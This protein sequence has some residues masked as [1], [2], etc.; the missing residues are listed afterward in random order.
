[1]LLVLSTA[2]EAKK[3]EIY[4]C[5][6][7]DGTVVIQDR[8][9]M[10]TDLHSVK[11]SKHQK[12]QVNQRANNQSSSPNNRQSQ[13]PVEISKHSFIT[14]E[15]I[16]SGRSPFFDLG[17]DQFIPAYWNKLKTNSRNHQQLL[18]S[19]AQLKN[20]SGFK[21]GVKLSVYS[22]AM[23]RSQQDPF[24]KA[25]QLY[26]QIRNNDSFQ[27]L[28]S[29]FKAHPNYKV[30]NIKYQ[31]QTQQLLLTEFYIDEKHNDLFVVTIQA[32]PSNW[33]TNQAMAEKIVDQL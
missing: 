33:Q 3:P 11:P 17:W 28:D 7:K 24:A 23:S 29:Q 10:I 18:L 6:Q 26:H 9:C 32:G 25:L 19:R 15:Q 5:Q 4:R 30:F 14:S 20:I 1:M 31:N 12:P 2:I 8:R 27:L 22:D 16:T 13:I 21:Q